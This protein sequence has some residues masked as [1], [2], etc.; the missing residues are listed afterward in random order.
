M[1]V[2]VT[3]GL[4]CLTIPR[5]AAR[6]VPSVHKV[7]RDLAPAA[8]L[9]PTGGKKRWILSPEVAVAKGLRDVLASS[10]R[11]PV[12]DR[13]GWETITALVTVK[14]YPAISRKS[15]ESVCVAGI[16]LDTSR[17][18]W[19][20]L[21]PVGFRDLP[22]EQQ[23][24]KYQVVSLRAKRGNS[25]RR[26]E[27]FKPDLSSLQLGTTVDA[28][29]GSWR[30]RWEIVE[31]FAGETTACEL[32][33]AAKTGGQTAPSLGLVKF[34]GAADLV[35]R[36]NP[37]FRPGGPVEVDVDLFG[38]E[39]EVL[40]KTPFIV[41]YRYRCASRACRGHEQSIV[42]WESGQLARRNL[43]THMLDEA[44]ALH[45]ARFLDAMCSSRRDTY[46]FVG[47]QHQHPQSFLVLGVFWPPAGS[48][49]S[50]TLGF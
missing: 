27:S 23:F 20:R 15:G 11:A 46:F 29:Q 10:V 41:S 47:N 7:L 13:A 33:D 25:D 31:E 17:P 38:T 12:E 36:D 40:E 24:K 50:P 18:E 49:P 35:I 44:K 8:R 2:V 32:A 21:F 6:H 48:R 4:G 34:A 37:D 19:V 14:A 3:D 39:R 42:D 9:W 45:R 30:R 1:P 16:R 26:Q 43:Q 22:R 5:I 28:D